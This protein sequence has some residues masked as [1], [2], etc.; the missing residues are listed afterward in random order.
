MRVKELYKKGQKSRRFREFYENAKLIAKDIN[1]LSIDKKRGERLLANLETHNTSL[2]AYKNRIYSDFNIRQYRSKAEFEQ[3]MYD[4]GKDPN[5]V[6]KLWKQYKHR[7]ELIETGQYAD[8]RYGIYRERYMKALK[9]MNVDEVYIKNLDKLTTGQFVRLSQIQDFS[10]TND[11]KYLLPTLGTFDYNLI[12][13]H[14]NDKI[15]EIEDAIQKAIE[16]IKVDFDKD[17]LGKESIDFDN[18]ITTYKMRRTISRLTQEKSQEYHK[19]NDESEYVINAYEL[20]YDEIKK[21]KKIYK[22]YGSYSVLAFIGSSKE[23]GKNREFVQG[24]RNYIRNKK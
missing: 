2:Q 11:T 18:E 15:K 5:D 14:A 16:G 3:H 21:G 20:L 19:V 17:I 24:F 8:Y 10:T 7:D 1:K 12:G 23:D 13:V 22:D 9:Q 6:E 4:L